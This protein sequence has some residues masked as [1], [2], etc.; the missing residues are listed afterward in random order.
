MRA[1]I[2][3]TLALAGEAGDYRTFRAR[4]YAERLS[5]GAN[6]ADARE[7]VPVAL[8]LFRLADGDVRAAIVYGANFGRDADTI[9]SMAGAL[10]GAWQGLAAFPAGWVEQMRAQSPR[11]HEDVAHGLVD[12]LLRR[13]EAAEGRAAHLRAS[14]AG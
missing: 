9:A 8:A 13:A 12:V 10:A 14:A 5:F 6:M 11:A 2:E 4:Y 3:G 1:C 7:T